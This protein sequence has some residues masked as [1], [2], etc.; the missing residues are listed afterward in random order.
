MTPESIQFVPA[1]P[2]VASIAELRH[3]VERLSEIPDS[4]K[5]AFLPLSK[6]ARF[7]GISRSLAGR[8][9]AAAISEGRLE[10]LSPVLNGT[11]GNPLYSVHDFKLFL[12]NKK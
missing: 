7:F 5:P 3:L 11:K 12:T 1:E 6:L 8:Y 9:V 2:L 10:H 4:T